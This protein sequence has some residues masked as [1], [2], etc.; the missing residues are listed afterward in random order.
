MYFKPCITSNYCFSALTVLLLTYNFSINRTG[1]CFFSPYI[2]NCSISISLV[3]L[4]HLLWFISLPSRI[5]SEGT[6]DPIYSLN[7]NGHS[8]CRK[9]CIFLWLVETIVMLYPESLKM[10]ICNG[11]WLFSVSWNLN[12][13]TLGVIE[14]NTEVTQYIMLWCH[15]HIGICYSVL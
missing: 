2:L 10:N 4:L 9:Y 8:A 1:I 3:L 11:D 12:F 13:K 7:D 5:F 14:L 6:K 15:S